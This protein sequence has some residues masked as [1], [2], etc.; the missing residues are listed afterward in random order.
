MAEH[1][2]TVGHVH[3]PEPSLAQT[4]DLAQRVAIDRLRIFQLDLEERARGALRRSTWIA[5]GFLFL[6]AAWIGLLG[7]AVFALAERIPL[8][9]SLLVVAT[10]QLLI[11]AGAILWGRRVRSCA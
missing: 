2:M 5:V 6:L 9:T 3:S 11:G 8:S 4:I 10:S 1:S 7:A